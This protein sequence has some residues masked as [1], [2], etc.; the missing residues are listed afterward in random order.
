MADTVK[1]D[2]RLQEILDL[3]HQR[4]VD[5]DVVDRNWFEREAPEGAQGIALRCGPYQ[6]ERAPDYQS[7]AL[8]ELPILA[9]DQVEVPRNVGAL[10]G[11]AEAVGVGLVVMPADRA[12][13]ITPAAVNASAGAAEH[14]RVAR[15]VNLARWIDEAKAAGYWIVGMAM[16]ERASPVFDVEMPSP[17]VLVV[18][19]EGHGLRRLTVE[20]CDL[21]VYLPMIGEVESLNA[22]AAGSIALYEVQKGKLRTS[23]SA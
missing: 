19:S 22:A 16:D 14:L 13:E 9:R 3:C 6:Y 10:L 8:Q 23:T 7:L 17:T 20:R 12:A 18:G 1:Q 21:L 15:V 5:V 4:G 2:Q 11:T